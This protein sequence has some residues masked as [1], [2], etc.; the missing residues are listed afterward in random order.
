MVS[1]IC[2][3]T[4]NL[5]NY[6]NTVLTMGRDVIKSVGRVVTYV[7]QFVSPEELIAS[8]GRTIFLSG[9]G[10][11]GGYHFWDLQTIFSKE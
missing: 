4:C 9:G 8:K 6:S 2:S 3:F 1:L 11:G 5:R 10:G 7:F